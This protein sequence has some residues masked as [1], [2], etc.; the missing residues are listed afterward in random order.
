[1]HL[2]AHL[3]QLASLST[4]FLLS[5]L[6]AAQNGTVTCEEGSSSVSIPYDHLFNA[7][8]VPEG[9][10]SCNVTLDATSATE[11][12]ANGTVVG[13]AT[14]NGTS[15]G[16]PNTAPFGLLVIDSPN[17]ASVSSMAYRSDWRLLGCH[18]TS[19]EPQQVLAYCSKSMDDPTSGCSHVFIGQPEHTIV[20]MPAG[21]GPGPYAHVTGLSEHPHSAIRRAYI[22]GKPA[23]ESVYQLSF[24]YDFTSLPEENAPI[25]MRADVSNIPGYWDNVVEATPGASKHAVDGSDVQPPEEKVIDTVISFVSWIA[26]IVKGAP[27]KGGDSWADVFKLGGSVSWGQSAGSESLGGSYNIALSASGEVFTRYAYYISATINP[28]NVSAAYVYFGGAVDAKAE[29][30]IEGEV[31]ASYES[32][33]KQFGKPIGLPGLSYPGLL[34]VGPSLSLEGYA[35]GSLQLN[36]SVNVTVGYSLPY[37]EA[38]LGKTGQDRTPAPYNSLSNPSSGL[39]SDIDWNFTLS[40]DMSLHLVP[41]LQLGINVLEGVLLDAQGYVSA[42]VAAGLEAEASAGAGNSGTICIKPYVD[43]EFEAGLTGKL[44][45]WDIGNQTW[46]LWNPDKLYIPTDGICPVKPSRR[47]TIDGQTSSWSLGAFE[48]ES[49]E[50][51]V[52]VASSRIMRPGLGL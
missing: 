33:R 37:T 26:A 47:S 8:S 13:T 15:D 50:S 30:L 12:D 32:E 5:Q 46:P 17:N 11:T 34:R 52:N 44:L 20:Q 4:I 28:K 18:P 29:V 45:Y 23:S 9:A 21:C 38:Y 41:R 48:E 27:I 10:V 42:D 1:M 31:H 7:S 14:Y 43:V 16:T 22:E 24:D 36:G 40:G 49:N 51:R 35:A 19:E 25:Y 39:N 3:V 2:S 6:V